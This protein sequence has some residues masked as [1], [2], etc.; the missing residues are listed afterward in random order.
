MQAE[1]CF[2]VHVLKV[3]LLWEY[4]WS[5]SFMSMQETLLNMVNDVQHMY[6]Q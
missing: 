3:P 4:P 2:V 1:I 5:I 6:I